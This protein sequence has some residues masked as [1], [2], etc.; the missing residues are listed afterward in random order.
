MADYNKLIEQIVNTGL[1]S[2]DNVWEFCNKL[3]QRFHSTTIE[4]Y[5]KRIESATEFTEVTKTD[6]KIKS[7]TAN[8]QFRD[9]MQNGQKRLQEQKR[10]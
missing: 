2:N 10:K 7:E 3:F 4:E 5:I 1:V 6:V 8:Q 9:N